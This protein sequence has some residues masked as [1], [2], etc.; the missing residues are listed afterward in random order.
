MFGVLAVVT[1]IGL[2]W[3]VR[4]G[5]RRALDRENLDLVKVFLAALSI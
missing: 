5:L 2:R 4:D 1:I 3:L